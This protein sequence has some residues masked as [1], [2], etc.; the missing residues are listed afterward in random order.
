MTDVSCSVRRAP[1]LSGPLLVAGLLLIS[2]GSVT[3]QSSHSSSTVAMLNMAFYGARATSLRPD[4]SLLAGEATVRLREQLGRALQGKAGVLLLDSASV[5]SALGSSE[6][7]AAA[8]GKPCNVVVACARAIGRKLRASWVVMGK[9]SK[10]SDLIWI[11]SGQLID[12]ATGRLL[13]DDEYELK[14]IA[15]DMVAAGTRVFARRVAK[16]I[17]E[18]SRAEASSSSGRTSMRKRGLGTSHSAPARQGLECFAYG[19]PPTSRRGLRV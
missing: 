19:P 5:G 14:G 3:A 8:N 1:L 16:K 12:V 2:A 15:R 4:D 10:T 18:A 6:A 7:R 17:G 13:M 11:F 9:V